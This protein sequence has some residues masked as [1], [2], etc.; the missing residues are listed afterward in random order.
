MSDSE[1][2]VPEVKDVA[3]IFL[4]FCVMFGATTLAIVVWLSTTMSLYWALVVAAPFA[5]AAGWLSSLSRPLRRTLSAIVD[6]LSHV[7]PRSH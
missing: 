2:R 5:V 7:R 4:T 3:D 1:K 6:L